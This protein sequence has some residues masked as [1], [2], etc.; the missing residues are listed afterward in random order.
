ML[1]I[2]IFWIGAYNF[3]S[4]H[5]QKLSASLIGWSCTTGFYWDMLGY[6]QMETF[7]HPLGIGVFSPVGFDFAGASHLGYLPSYPV[8]REFGTLSGDRLR[9]QDTHTKLPAIPHPA[10]LLH[11]CLYRT[12]TGFN[13]S[14]DVVPAYRGQHPGGTFVCAYQ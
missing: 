1:F 7:Y 4:L 14:S 3:Q 10:E 8:H 6:G 9:G 2:P 13:H 12:A 5:P 11:L